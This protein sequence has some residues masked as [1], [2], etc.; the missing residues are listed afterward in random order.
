MTKEETKEY[1]KA[2]KL[3]EQ[4]DRLFKLGNECLRQSADAM[5]ESNEIQYKLNQSMKKPRLKIV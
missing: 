3:A 4:A 2:K 1:Q 5:A